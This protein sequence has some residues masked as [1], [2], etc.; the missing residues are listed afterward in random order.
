MKHFI[1]I[2]ITSLCTT[3]GAFAHN[4]REHAHAS[5]NER[6]WTS[7]NKHLTGALS[8][9]KAGMVYIEKEHDLIAVPYA[10]L[11]EEDRAYVDKRYEMI[12]RFN[13]PRNQHINTPI[14]Y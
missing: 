2:L 3:I 4:A 1:L 10:T 13:L 9:M 8:F 6:H 7:G 11:G 14:S 5:H 12:R